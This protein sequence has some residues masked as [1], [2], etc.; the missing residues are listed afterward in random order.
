MNFKKLYNKILIRVFI[1]F[2]IFK[3]YIHNIY[4]SYIKNAK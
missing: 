4:I 3:K 1:Y 2:N